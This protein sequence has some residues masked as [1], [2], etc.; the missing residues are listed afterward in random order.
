MFS[1]NINYLCL[2]CLSGCLMT[3]FIINNEITTYN[4]KYL[5][6]IEYL[7]KEISENYDYTKKENIH[8]RREINSLELHKNSEINS[9]NLISQK[10]LELE[11]DMIFKFLRESYFP[12]GIFNLFIKFFDFKNK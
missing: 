1:K 7:K 11:N 12:K 3:Y 6:E 4:K 2:G 8:H 10:K 5:N 9:S